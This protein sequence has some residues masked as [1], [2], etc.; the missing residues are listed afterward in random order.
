MKKKLILMS[1]V[2]LLV[3]SSSAFANPGRPATVCLERSRSGDSVKFENTCGEKIFVMYC[4]DLKHSNQNCGDGPNGGYYTHTQNIAPYSSVTV[5]TKGKIY[6]GS[7]Y[8]GVS[9][10]KDEFSDSPNGDFIC[11]KT[12][13]GR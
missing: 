8:G 6:S 4:G 5:Q 7:C 2:T 12:G 1:A 9:F 13:N 3:C 10:G 11:K